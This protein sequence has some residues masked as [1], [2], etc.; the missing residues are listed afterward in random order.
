MCQA[1][2]ALGDGIS[3]E[4]V[5][6]VVKKTAGSMNNPHLASHDLRRSRVRS[7]T[8][9]VTTSRSLLIAIG[10]AWPGHRGIISTGE[11]HGETDQLSIRYTLAVRRSF[12]NEP[13]IK[14]QI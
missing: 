13:R 2:K 4:T 5:W 8:I 9:L 10:V 11:D 12:F 1:G 6:H 3:E 7:F 14:S